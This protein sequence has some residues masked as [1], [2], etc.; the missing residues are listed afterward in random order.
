VDFLGDYL[1]RADNIRERSAGFQALRQV[2][3]RKAAEVALALL[4]LLPERQRES[5]RLFFERMLENEP[6]ERP[7]P[8]RRE[9]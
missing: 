7:E 1:K 8:G 3:T 2:G 9:N 6:I 4:D 5:Q